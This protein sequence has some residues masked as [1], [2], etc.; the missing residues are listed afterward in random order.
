MVPA[1]TYNMYFQRKLHC[2]ISSISK[3]KT[4]TRFSR[5]LPIYCMRLF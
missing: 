4:Y 1:G 3:E 2:K 5:E